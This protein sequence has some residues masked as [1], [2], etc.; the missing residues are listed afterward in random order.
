MPA[1]SVTC[2]NCRRRGH[3]IEECRTRTR[4][5][6][7]APPKSKLDNACFN[8]NQEG[9]YSRQCPLPRK[10]GSRPPSSEAQNTTNEQLQHPKVSQVKDNDVTTHAVYLPATLGKIKLNCLLDSRCD[11][12]I[13]PAKL[14]KGGREEG[15][16]G[17]KIFLSLYITFFL[18]F[19][20]PDDQ[21]AGIP[22]CPS[23]PPSFPPSFPT[24][25]PP[26]KKKKIKNNK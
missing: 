11:V 2:A 19:F 9:D 24:S 3:G 20:L 7:S 23:L 15:R 12:T 10:G 26:S 21:P 6:T 14:K 5:H 18:F 16:K 22:V 17:G 25:L 1:M 13:M 4:A 8:C